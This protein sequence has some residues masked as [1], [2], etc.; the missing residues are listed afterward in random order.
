MT[1]D[2]K[3]SKRTICVFCGSASGKSDI[4]AKAAEKLALEMAKRNWDLVYG[5]M[6][7]YI[8]PLSNKQGEGQ[9]V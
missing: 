8:L 3:T 2:G 4:Y 5:K 1:T 7:S 9:L 6:R